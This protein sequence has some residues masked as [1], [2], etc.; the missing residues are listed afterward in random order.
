MMAGRAS[1]DCAGAVRLTGIEAA[2]ASARRNGLPGY[3]RWWA[4]LERRHTVMPHWYW[5]EQ[6][7]RR[8][9]IDHIRAAIDWQERERRISQG[10][11]D[12]HRGL[13]RHI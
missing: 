1:P 10:N 9:Y 12:F 3:G 13:V 8:H 4:G 6:E 11:A 2:E 5:N 7:C